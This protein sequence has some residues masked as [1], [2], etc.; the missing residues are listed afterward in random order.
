MLVSMK[1]FKKVSTVSFQS[2]KRKRNKKTEL[3]MSIANQY[4]LYFCQHEKKLQDDILIQISCCVVEILTVCTDYQKGL[5]NP[6][7]SSQ[8]LWSAGSF[9]ISPPGQRQG[10]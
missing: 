9:L 8:G 10:M 3:V 6:G 2:Y 7:S 1:V 4:T 5:Q